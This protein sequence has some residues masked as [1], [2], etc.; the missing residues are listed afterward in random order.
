MTRS[1]DDAHS[2]KQR[3][4]QLLYDTTGIDKDW[5][6]PVQ[7]A[8][9]IKA[10]YEN[11]NKTKDEL[12]TA[13]QANNILTSKI[14]H[15]L[16]NPISSILMMASA[17][18]EGHCTSSQQSQYIAA[19]IT[20][21]QQ[22]LDLVSELLESSR[23]GQQSLPIKQKT[24]N[25]KD[26][27]DQ[28]HNELSIRAYQYNNEYRIHWDDNIPP[29]LIGD[30]IQ[31]RRV[32]YNLSDNALKFTKQGY[33]DVYADLVGRPQEDEVTIQFQIQD[34][35]LGIP[36]DKLANIFGDYEQVTSKDHIASN[37][38]WRGIGLGLAIV[39]DL[40]DSMGG[41][42]HVTSKEGQGTLFWFSLT[43]KQAPQATVVTHSE[44]TSSQPA[45]QI[46]PR[47]LVVDDDA[48]SRRAISHLCKNQNC[49]VDTTSDQQQT[50]EQLNHHHYDIVL[51]DMFLKNN[52]G[53][54][55]VKEY[56]AQHPQNASS[57]KFY[58]LTASGRYEDQQTCLQAGMHDV[59]LKP[60][61]VK[62]LQAIID[63]LN[64]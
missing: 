4:R 14:T 62:R 26:L 28:I 52:E 11:I 49:Q 1:Q 15:D 23:N 50:L 20:C 10:Y 35:G 3:L 44:K 43:F 58:A 21:S 55:I 34:T 53:P 5:D 38:Q 56:F 17:I 30:A 25:L 40:V 6:D 32:L 31:L 39:Q 51:M 57:P 59:I 16:R 13:N 42:V 2:T 61:T 12:E 18:Q 41:Q 64:E 27:L 33:I 29:H 47:V 19:I 45:R 36:Q 22:L 9:E 54:Q 48:I 60:L 63:S 7:Y 8:H 46:K 24:F 37:R